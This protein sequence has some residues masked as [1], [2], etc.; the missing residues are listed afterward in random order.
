MSHKSVSK[1]LALLAVVGL[2]VSLSGTFAQSFMIGGMY[3]VSGTNPNGSRYQGSVQISQNDD[4]SYTFEWSVG[5]NYSGTGSLQG[6]VLSVDW[7]D[8]YPV[9]YNVKNGGARLEGTWGNGAGT[10][11]LYK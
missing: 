3:K 7:G 4:G 9:I 6:N 5:N 8:T 1:L 10:E 11:I 2:V